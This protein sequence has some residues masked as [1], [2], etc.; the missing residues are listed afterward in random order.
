MTFT[1]ACYKDELSLIKPIDT[2]EIN[3]KDFNL[4]LDSLTPDIQCDRKRDN[5]DTILPEV[6]QYYT[7]ESS[8]Y[9]VYTQS[10]IQN[11]IPSNF[12]EKHGMDYHTSVIKVLEHYPGTFSYPHYDYYLS[13]KNKEKEQKIQRLWIPC[14]DSKFGHAFFVDIDVIYKYKAGDV[15]VVPDKKLHSGTNAGLE[16]RRILTITGKLCQI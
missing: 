9:N 13:L 16:K 12:V 10:C 8:T 3:W 5:P 14:T 1:V 11:K 4:L 7:L 2:L 15:F 6:Y